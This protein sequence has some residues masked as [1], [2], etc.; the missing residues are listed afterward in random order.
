M[1]AIESALAAVP[2]A[3][4]KTRAFASKRSEKRACSSVDQVSPP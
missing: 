3:T 4:Q 1:A 2:V